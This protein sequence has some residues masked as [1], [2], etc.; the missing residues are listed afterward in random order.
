MN[1]GQLVVNFAALTQA[2]SDITR[3][4]GELQS[5]LADLDAHGK[6][7]MDTWDGD[8]RNAYLDKQNRWN[9]AAQD[10]TAILRRIQTALDAS[11]GDYLN[12][13]K[14]ATSLFQ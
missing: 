13:E 1:N 7:L 3:A 2:S 10:L 4:L 9:S 11:Q 14:R 8:A 6:R 5:Q 12:T